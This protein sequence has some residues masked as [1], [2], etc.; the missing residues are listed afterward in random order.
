[1]PD[2]RAILARMLTV[3]AL[4]LVITWTC[5]ASSSVHLQNRVVHPFDHSD[6]V[7]DCLKMRADLAT[8]HNTD[9]NYYLY[10]A[11]YSSKVTS[12]HRHDL[13]GHYGPSA[14][15]GHASPKS[16]LMRAH[17]AHSLQDKPNL[18]HVCQ[19]KKKKTYSMSLTYLTQLL[20]LTILQPTDKLSPGVLDDDSDFPQPHRIRV[21]SLP[22][23]E[24]HSYA[25][26]LHQRWREQVGKS[27]ELVR[28]R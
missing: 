18:Q 1:M 21:I 14:V 6:K 26:A 10:L 15:I 22:A 3:G 23:A 16:V 24:E 7:R 9:D 2:L 19:Q 20:S 13:R 4:L 5:S 28:I 11:H 8:Q 12:A 27:D 17:R 25:E